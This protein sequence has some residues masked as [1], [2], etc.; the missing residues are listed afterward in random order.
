MWVQKII[1]DCLALQLKKLV[2]M[3]NL[4][5]EVNMSFRSLSACIK[6]LIL[7]NVLSV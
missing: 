1:L 5:N 4:L 7:L 3:N 2:T 6:F